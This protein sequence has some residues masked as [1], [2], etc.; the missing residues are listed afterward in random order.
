M[1]TDQTYLKDAEEA[2]IAK[3]RAALKEVPGEPSRSTKV[4]DALN[5][6]QGIT[7]S[8]ITRMLA[9]SLDPSRWKKSVQPSEPT[10]VTQAQTSIRT[11]SLAE[12]NVKVA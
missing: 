2:W 5:R 1:A 9:R 11:G 8:N 7:I 10:P 3:Y 6:A 4:R 12:S